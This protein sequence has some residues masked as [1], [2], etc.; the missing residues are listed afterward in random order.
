MRISKKDLKKAVIEFA[1]NT[2]SYLFNRKI[3]QKNLRKNLLTSQKTSTFASL[4]K[5]KGIPSGV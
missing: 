3:M 1:C 5:R 4:L 2:E